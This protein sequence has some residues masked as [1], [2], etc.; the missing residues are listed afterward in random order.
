MCRALM[1][2]RN[3][4]SVKSPK[5]G[6]VWVQKPVP[7]EPPPNVAGSNPCSLIPA[8]TRRSRAGQNGAGGRESNAD[9]SDASSANARE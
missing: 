9:E 4:E 8:D 1:P 6:T 5:S 2:K 3:E 7:A